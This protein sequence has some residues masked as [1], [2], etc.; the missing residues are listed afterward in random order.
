MDIRER[1]RKPLGRGAICRAIDG[2]V[3]EQ[4]IDGQSGAECR[5]RV[6]GRRE[7]REIEGRWEGEREVV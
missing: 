2:R 1:T 3:K 6:R 4:S 7:S 5:R